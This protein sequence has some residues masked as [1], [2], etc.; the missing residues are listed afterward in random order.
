MM[1][2]FAE[3]VDTL[4]A[5][6]NEEDCHHALQVLRLREGE[7]LKAVVEGAC[8]EAV[9]IPQGREALL[10]L[11]SPL[12]DPEPRL[13]ITLYQGLPKGDKMELIIQ[14]ACEL[15]VHR[16]VPCLFS[17]C[18]AR[19]HPGQ[20]GS[21]I[22]RFQKIAK[23]AAMQ[24]GRAQIPEVAL[25]LQ[26]PDIAPALSRHAESLIFWEEALPAPLKTV[27]E[28]SLDLA[29][30]VG[31]EGGMSASEVSALPGKKASLGP[32]IL[33]T[34]TAGIAGVSALMALSQEI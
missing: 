32:R 1:S 11:G 27:Y 26:F 8:F 12:P 2:F 24:S 29:I 28:G 13:K 17:R 9:L 3:R 14:K 20:E 18:V 25:P 4:S 7:K 5:R 10:K 16:I 6:L 23:E 15:G 21:K 30:L 22:K 34:E 31:P 19:I 33:R